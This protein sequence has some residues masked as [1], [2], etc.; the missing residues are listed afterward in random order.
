MANTRFH[1]I[2]L[3]DVLLPDILLPVILLPRHFA[4]QT[5]CY[6]RHFATQTLCYLDILL[7]RH[8]ATSDILLPPFIVR[9]FAT[10]LYMKIFF[11][12]IKLWTLDLCSIY[13]HTCPK[14]ARCMV[15]TLCV[16]L[17]T[18]HAQT[19]APQPDLHFTFHLFMVVT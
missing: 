17:C 18:L 6:L 11:F 5:F 12:K 15:C 3:P 9:H 7:P 4:T 1:D 16:L 19:I 10:S 2:L 14:H 13:G 8:F